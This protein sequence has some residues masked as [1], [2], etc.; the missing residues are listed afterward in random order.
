MTKS[1][2]LMRHLKSEIDAASGSDHDRALS[3]RGRADAKTIRDALLAR[4]P[5]PQTVLC[6]TAKRTRE[7][8][9]GIG[10]LFPGAEII[11]TDTIYE[12]SADTLMRATSMIGDAAACAMIIGHNPGIFDFAWTL[13]RRSEI[14][15]NPAFVKFPT[16]AV[17][18]F[19]LPIDSWTEIGTGRGSIIA[20]FTPKSLVKA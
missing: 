19:A 17:A 16:G 11:F 6:S 13:A 12:A 1:L 10:D 20:A 7:T 9:A 14:S 8:L 4:C 15:G 3:E 18:A 5:P 2:I